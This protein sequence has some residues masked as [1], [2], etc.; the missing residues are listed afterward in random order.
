MLKWEHFENQ[1]DS[2]WHKWV[3]PIIENQK[4]YE[5]FSKL[6][7]LSKNQKVIPSSK[8]G[9]LFR[10]FR[11]VPFDKMIVAVVGLSPYNVYAEGGIEVADGIALSCSNTG[12][13]QPTLT[14]WYNAME[15]EFGK[16]IERE[17]DLSYLTKQGIFMY[18]YSLTCGFKDATGHIPVW[19]WFSKELFRTAISHAEVPVITLGKEAAKVIDSTLPW[20]KVFELQHPA[21]ASY[22]KTTWDSKRAFTEVKKHLADKGIYFN[23]TITKQNKF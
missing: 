12:K 16:S 23:W 19:E 2:S 9:N 11:E 22:A 20:Q 13:E 7:E 14:Q 21:A 8:S 1:F 10:I 15:T 17:P 4:F 6:K 5:D 18:N 3:K